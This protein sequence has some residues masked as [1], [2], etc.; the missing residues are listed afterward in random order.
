MVAAAVLIALVGTVA[1][2]WARVG[3]GP[4]AAALVMVSVAVAA[5]LSGIASSRT[6]GSPFEFVTAAAG[7][8][9]KPTAAI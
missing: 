9:V 1:A 3:D 4:R 7:R 2:T 8:H 6:P 5:L